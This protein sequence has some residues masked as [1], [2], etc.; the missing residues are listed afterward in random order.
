[1]LFGCTKA[2]TTCQLRHPWFGLIWLFATSPINH[3]P[4]S[5]FPK[6]P[7]LALV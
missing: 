1:M 3:P 5:K 2:S 4:S 7:S 6:L